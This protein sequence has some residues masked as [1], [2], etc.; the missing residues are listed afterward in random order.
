MKQMKFDGIFEKGKTLLTRNLG[1]GPVYGERFIKEG[2]LQY[3]EWEPRRSKLAAAIMKGCSV[4][5]LREHDIVLY[6]GASTGTTASHV[7][8]IVGNRG[9]VFALDS[10]PRVMRHLYFIC[11]SRKNMAPILADAAQPDT[12]KDRV[13]QVDYVYQDIAQRDQLRI[14]L[15]N[16]DAFLEKGGF[17]ALCVKARSIDIARRPK[18]IF[19]ETRRELEKKMTIIDYRLLEPYEKDH[20]MFFV[21]KT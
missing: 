21:K 17:G 19:Q 5:G 1:A 11:E 4:S 16:C 8:D 9:F 3:R 20:C 7:S 18:D 12:F 13:S 15:L 6:L 14:F 10:A 2:K